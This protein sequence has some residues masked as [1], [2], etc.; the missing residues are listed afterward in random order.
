MY[1]SVIPA[2][3]PYSISSKNDAAAYP[4]LHPQQRLMPLRFAELSI[5]IS[6]I[7]CRRVMI[8]CNSAAEY[9]IEISLYT[10][11]SPGIFSIS[12]VPIARHTVSPTEKSRRMLPVRTRLL[13]LTMWTIVKSCPIIFS[14]SGTTFVL[15]VIS[16]ERL[17]LFFGSSV[18]ISR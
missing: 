7:K 18:I 1:L 17:S 13:P 6:C 9:L 12:N 16:C 15:L 11:L 8:F 3:M 5:G 10:P 14:T 2:S 4:T